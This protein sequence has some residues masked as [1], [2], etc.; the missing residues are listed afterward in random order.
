MIV[1]LT[2]NPSLDRTLC[3]DVLRRGAVIRASAATLDAS[4][5]GVNVSRALVANHIPTRAVL[6]LGGGA[7]IQLADLLRA[8]GVEFIPIRCAGVVRSNVSVAEPDGTVTKLNEP[9]TP[10]A[11]SETAALVDACLPGADWVAGCGSLPPDTAP[12]L[13]AT[14]VTRARAA[15]VRAAV[16]A[17]GLPLRLALQ[18]GPDLLKPNVAELAELTGRE[19]RTVADVVGAAQA[20]RG[21]AAMLVSMGADGALLIDSDGVRHGEAP[22]PV[23]R[24]A[25]GAGDALL[26][27]FLAAGG[28]GDA[29]LVTGLAWA[30]AVCALPGTAVP[31]PRALRPSAVVVRHDIR[32]DRLLTEQHPPRVV[33]EDRDPCTHSW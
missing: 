25:V 18:A 31:E 21:R 4:G 14:L 10:L 29:A 9:G 12:E 22:V 26:A 8:G 16:D 30:A 32:E 28:R 11:P 2:P 1:T 19:L 17:S 24:S 20:V 27:G 6:P 33:R 15:G 13:Y 5:K 23:L 3:V 7:G